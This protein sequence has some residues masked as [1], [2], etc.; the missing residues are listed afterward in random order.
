MLVAGLDVFGGGL[1]SAAAATPPE[2]TACQTE[3]SFQME[4]AIDPAFDFE[5]AVAVGNSDKE[6]SLR[7]EPGSTSAEQSRGVVYVFKNLRT[8][9]DIEPDGGARACRSPQRNRAERLPVSS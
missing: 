8:D 1:C 4:P 3:D 6:Q 5:R 9:D 7:V 2:P